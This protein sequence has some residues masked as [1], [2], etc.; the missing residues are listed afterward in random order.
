MA[1][2]KRW[3]AAVHGL[4]LG[5]MLV[6]AGL[7]GVG[8]GGCGAEKE[9]APTPAQPAPAAKAVPAPPPVVEAPAAP[10]VPKP[11]VVKRELSEGAPVVLDIL[12]Y[13]PATAQL[14]LALPPLNGTIA[15]AIPFA[16]RIAP[17][18]VDIEAEVNNIIRD[19]AIDAGAEGADSF[20]AIAEAKGI[21]LDAPMGLFI[22]VTASVD[23]AVAAAAEA[24][25]AATPQPEEAPQVE[26]QAD[27]GGEAAEAPGD[28]DMQ[29]A[30]EDLEM[31]AL[32]LALGITDRAKAEGTLEEIV[33]AI[34]DLDGVEPQQLTVG[35]VAMTTYATPQGDYGY[36]FAGDK[37]FVGTVSLLK[38]VVERL[39]APA[40]IRY[41]SAECPA[42]APDEAAMLVYSNR[43]LPLIKKALPVM[44]LGADM[45]PMLEVQM[46]ALEAMLGGAD[47]KEDP[48]VMTLAWTDT[49][50]ELKSRMDTATHPGILEFSGKAEPLKLAQL[51]PEGTLAMLSLCLSDEYKKQI[52]DVYMN[53]LPAEM[54]KDAS[55]AF[56]IGIATQV[57][58]ILGRELT[59][60]ITG[61]EDDLPGVFLLVDLAQPEA[62]RGLIQMGGFL[63]PEE[64]YREIELNAIAA[65]S[66][67]QF[68][69]AMPKNMILVASDLDK[70]K[71]MV[72][73]L[74]DGKTSNLFASL[75]PPL[76]PNMPV[77][78]GLILSSG[79][80]T[81]VLIPLSYLFGGIPED[82]EPIVGTVA[83]VLK[84]LRLFAEMDGSWQVS[85]L[86]LLLKE[87]AG[88]DA[89]AEESSET[90]P[91]SEEPAV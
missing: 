81:D 53:A 67:I 58:T 46:A 8:C 31:P 63:M 7:C 71:V 68:Y 86:S 69:L 23:S 27:E 36:F 89:A 33:D 42:T 29:V 10:E 37:L 15:K 82:L 48:A 91:T 13:T 1:I 80:L 60:G 47:T 5:L 11:A 39:A 26:A 6:G 16:K 41:G 54:K 25:A 24:K 83:E 43:L 44:D 2:P 76:D 57:L 77:Y 28:L 35:D 73:L 79:V 20:G 9:A 88:A 70:M 40:D 34:E 14:A 38:G 52:T 75:D 66:P 55:F 22:D 74:L 64:T 4:A 50:L 65:P 85:R 78:N 17:P 87:A 51:L 3:L 62:A 30:F 18:A 84:E 19:L 45:Q 90:K 32:V 59:L 21:S 12:A 56:G 49:L 72:D 61:V